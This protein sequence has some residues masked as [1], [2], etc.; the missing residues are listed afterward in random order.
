MNKDILNILN[1]CKTAYSLGET[2]VLSENEKKILNSELNIGLLEDK[3]DDFTFDLIYSEAKRLWPD[4]QYFN[5]LTS[6]NLGYGVDVKHKEPMGSMDELKSGDWDKWKVGHNEFIL[7]DKLDGCSV[8]ITY[9]GG[10]L[11]QAATRGRGLVGKCIMRHLYRIRNMVF[12]IPYTDEIVVRGELLCPKNE[13]KQMLDDTEKVTGKRQKNGRNTIAGALNRKETQFSIFDHAN[14]VAYWDSV[15]KG[16]N[17]EK[18]A[19][20]GFTTP[21]M[22]IVP[23]TITEEELIAIIKKRLIESDYE[24]DGIILTQ[25]DNPEPG[26][27]GSSLNPKASRKL[28]L[29]IYDNVATSTVTNINWQVSKHGALKPVLEIEPTEVCGCTVTHITGH[30]YENVINTKCGIGAKIKFC[31]AGLVIP[32]LQEV[33]EEST[34][35]NLPTF[36]IRKGVDIYLDKDKDVTGN[37]IEQNIKQLEY[38][39]KK[40]EIEQLGYGNCKKLYEAL[41]GEEIET[42]PET[43][44]TLPE[45]FITAIIG[46]NGKKIEASLAK[47]KENISQ[48]K[49]AAACGAFGP[50]IGEKVLDTVYKVYNT[51]DVDVDKL[52][53]LKGFAENRIVQYLKYLPNWLSIYAKML[54][55]GISFNCNQMI[56]K[57]DKFKDKVVCFSGIRDK[58]LIN[59]INENGGEASDN[60]KKNTNILVVKDL[61]G[62]SS[63]MSKAK[64][65]NCL[66]LNI[67]QAKEYF[68]G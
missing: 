65:S 15:D 35:Y 42:S 62:T 61:N 3:V 40:L 28:K 12:D 53:E 5:E 46:E 63:K 16:Q 33:L 45:G 21:Y 7:T 23:S 54:N 9:K 17:I 10:K 39:G 27:I 44:Y 48:A 38:F 56:N 59:Y 37:I 2:Y 60:W 8:V 49:F 25:K 43:L 19:S 20:W 57:S 52:K 66:I 36:Y 64:A 22:Q 50:A 32:Y 51:L 30:N 26:Y 41:Q 13:I 31:R 18:L 24:I 4:D 34:E 67:E 11:V 68:Y 47:S 55:A 58:D 29:G 14:F 6:E 1:N